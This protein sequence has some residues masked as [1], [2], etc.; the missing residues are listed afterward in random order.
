METHK[1]TLPT[2]T[3][4]EECADPIPV[5][6]DRLEWLEIRRS[7]IGG[8]DAATLMGHD[9]HNG[10][11]VIFESKVFPVDDT[12]AREPEAAYWGHRLED[13]VADEFQ[14]RTGFFV[15]PSGF[16]YRSKRWPWMLATVDRI[17]TEDSGVSIL[18]CKCR[19][20]FVRK[21][22]D[23]GVP[24]GIK[25]QCY[26]YMAVTGVS[27]VW[28]AALIGGN[29]FRVE[30]VDRDEEYIQQLVE[31]EQRFWED[32]VVARIPPPFDSSAGTRQIVESRF[33]NSTPG[34]TVDLPE[35]A[36]AIIHSLRMSR[37]VKN[38]FVEDEEALKTRLK[39]ML[40][41][42]EAGMLGGEIVVTWKQSRRS[43]VDA[44]RLKM[45]FP[46]IYKQVVRESG[47]RRFSVKGVE[48]E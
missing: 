19:S 35:E 6:D 24:A 16:M 11:L 15:R 1:V 8:S 20:S 44:H 26:H 42:A 27:R 14:N 34:K 4:F 12:E 31:T 40:E 30:I 21:Q 36:R 33:S 41:D 32:H 7:G 2:H 22:W 29:H 39:S 18:E 46:E 38:S 13:I 10:P 3:P 23:E 48:D 37:G 43:S 9:D 47:S 5:P 25:D 28:V 17:V 45:E